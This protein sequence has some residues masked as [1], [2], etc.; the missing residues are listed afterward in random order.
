MKVVF[1]EP[2]SWILHVGFIFRAVNRQNRNQRGRIT[3]ETPVNKMLYEM[4]LA[5]DF[6][7]ISPSLI[8][9]GPILIPI[10][11]PTREEKL[12]FPILIPIRKYFSGADS[13]SDSDISR[14]VLIVKSFY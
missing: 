2:P 11:I 6:L 13:D 9:F 1:F 14:N 12:K 10:P 3:L 8:F 7:T 4:P 5:S